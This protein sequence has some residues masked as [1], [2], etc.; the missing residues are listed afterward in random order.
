MQASE[1][2]PVGFSWDGG[3]LAASSYGKGASQ[4]DLHSVA[5][6]MPGPQPVVLS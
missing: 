3:S 2:L 5:E 4:Q 6:Q 1:V